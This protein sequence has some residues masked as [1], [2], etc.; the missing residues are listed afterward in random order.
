MPAKGRR[1][2]KLLDTSSQIHRS[3]GCSFCAFPFLSACKVCSGGTVCF[4]GG[5]GQG[6]LSES[7]SLS[8]SFAINPSLYLSAVARIVGLCLQSGLQ[9]RTVSFWL[10]VN[11]FFWRHMVALISISRRKGDTLMSLRKA[12]GPVPFPPLFFTLSMFLRKAFG[13]SS[14]DCSVLGGLKVAW[15][16]SICRWDQCR[17]MPLG[18]PSAYYWLDFSSSH[19]LLQSCECERGSTYL[20]LQGW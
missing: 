15:L 19:G 3:L 9:S 18:R 8:S 7:E 13:I 1:K 16:L 17:F 10:L 5:A 14:A 12:F 4:A 11:M 2:Q 6:S 20:S